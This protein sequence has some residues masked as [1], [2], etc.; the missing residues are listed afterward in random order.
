MN[1]CVL[2]V[3]LEPWCGAFMM[4]MSSLSLGTL[5]ASHDSVAFVASPV[6]R[7]S[8][9]PYSNSD[10]IEFAFSSPPMPCAG[11]LR[12]SIVMPPKSFVCPAL[13]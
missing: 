7:N 5:L 2:D 3:A 9:S 1:A 6:N 12:T 4:S 13:T 8:K 10:T 11:G